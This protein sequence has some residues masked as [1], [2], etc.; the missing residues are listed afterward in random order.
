MN[1]A[2]QPLGYASVREEKADFC[3]RSKNSLAHLS[4]TA[5]AAG[6]V[7]GGASSFTD[8]QV[9]LFTVYLAHNVLSY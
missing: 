3:S 9:Y 6:S 7:C 5:T 2:L 1:Q 8:Y 4:D